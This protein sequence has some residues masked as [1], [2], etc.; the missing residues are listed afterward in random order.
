L[1][2]KH[3]EYLCQSKGESAI[4]SVQALTHLAACQA[5]LSRHQEAK[6]KFQTC[7]EVY[8]AA[9]GSSNPETQR[10]LHNLGTA[11]AD[12]GEYEEA[13]VIYKEVILICKSSG[14]QMKKMLMFS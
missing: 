7:Y 14:K 6:D 13:E 1:F 10:C 9:F 11:C 2:E 5:E 8:K 4:S 3:W 12:L